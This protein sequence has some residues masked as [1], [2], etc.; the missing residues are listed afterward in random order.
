MRMDAKV[1][2]IAEHIRDAGG[3]A[4][5]V[6]G[7][8]RDRLLGIDSKDIDVEVFGLDLKQLKAVLRDFGAVMEVGRAFGVLKLKGLD[9]DFSLPRIDSKTGPGHRGFDVETRPELDFASAA[10]RRDLTVNSI[11]FDPLTDE[12]LDP[13]GG[14]RDLERGVLRATDPTQFADDPLRALRA[15]QLSARLEMPADTELLELCRELVLDEVSPERIFEEF[16]KLLCKGAKPSMGLEL[17][18]DAQLLRYFP[19]LAALVDVPQDSRWHPE[20][21][22]WTHTLMVVDEAALLRDGEDELALMFGAL[23]HD[24]GKPDV[25]EEH[26]GAIR[27]HGH[28]S[29]GVRHTEALLSRWRAPASLIKQ[30]CALVEHHLAPT[31]MVNQSEGPKAYRR[32]AR[33]LEAAGVTLALLERVARADQLGRLTLEAKQ[34]RFPAGDEFLLQ[35]RA[36]RVEHQA[37]HDLVMGRH[38]LDRGIEPGRR[39]GWILSRCRELQD[40]YPE[41]DADELLTLV[42]TELGEFD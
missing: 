24:L 12:Y 16:K 30:V 34:R 25:T 7:W 42:L 6:G 39:F 15:A 18:R 1:L 21:D 14:R 33:A 8:V 19:E 13:H 3:Q 38:L 37:P 36:A 4:V 9:V 40:E 28:S 32:L 2:I 26:E 11:G 31:Q 22:V 10:L 41:H 20:G 29:Q 17:L 5:V 27:S 35:A 23:C